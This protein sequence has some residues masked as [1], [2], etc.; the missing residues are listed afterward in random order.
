[1]AP[2]VRDLWAMTTRPRLAVLPALATLAT[3]LVTFVTIPADAQ[4]TLEPLR[5]AI[6]A[7]VAAV[8]GAVA[9]IYLKDLGDG[10]ELAIGADSAFHAASTMKLPVMIEYFRGVDAGRFSSSSVAPLRNRFASIVDGSPY[11]LSAGDDSDS[12]LYQRVGGDAPVRELV[13]R[14]ITRSSNLATNAVIELVGARAAN[15][16]AHA[17]GATTMRVLRGVEDGKAYQAG[18]NNSTSARDLG[19]LLEAIATGRAASTAST[20][21]MLAILEQQEFNAEIPAGLPAGTRVAHKTGWITATLH[22]AA[23]IFPPGHPPFV[24]VVLTRGIPDQKVAQRLIADVARMSWNA[25]VA[26]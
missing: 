24:L 26:P 7:R 12:A 8:P 9:G 21:S 10:G 14:M 22:D 11:T 4:R 13:E 1:M 3:A 2:P 16:T 25:L 17:L 19:A 18:L 15:A 6:E 5:A 23:I 20:Q